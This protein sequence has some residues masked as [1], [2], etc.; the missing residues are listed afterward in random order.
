MRTHTNKLL[1]TRRITHMANEDKRRVLLDW[2]A[3]KYETTGPGM[4]QTEEFCESSSIAFE[5]LRPVIGM[6][7]RQGVI[8]TVVGEGG[9]AITD[10]GY[11]IVRPNDVST[12]RTGDT[13]IQFQGAVTGSAIALDG[14]KATVTNIGSNNSNALNLLAELENEINKT[15]SD[16]SSKKEAIELV[17]GVKNQFESGSPSKPIVKTLLGGLSHISNVSA[18]V[19]AI[20]AL[21]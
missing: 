16:P 13:N 12:P 17:E 6:L 19:S 20:V 15:L 7:H 11:N 8:R 5:E 4:H 1:N 10:Y 14:S 18:I 9:V 2:L 3:D 21:L